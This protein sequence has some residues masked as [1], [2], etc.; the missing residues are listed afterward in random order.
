MKEKT[1]VW[2]AYLVCVAW[3]LGAVAVVVIFASFDSR[4]PW[5]ELGS[6]QLVALSMLLFCAL[7]IAKLM[8]VYRRPIVEWRNALKLDDENRQS[9]I[10]LSLDMAV[11]AFFVFNMLFSA[12]ENWRHSGFWTPSTSLPLFEILLALMAASYIAAYI[13]GLRRI[14]RERTKAGPSDSTPSSA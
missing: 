4:G 2:G 12:R 9:A 3:P 8:P 1:D 10:W 5:L 11:S 13:A 14:S 6:L 7:E